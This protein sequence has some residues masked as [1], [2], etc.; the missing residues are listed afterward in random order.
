MDLGLTEEPATY[1]SQ[2]GIGRGNARMLWPGRRC[3][4]L[5]QRGNLPS[6]PRVRAG[7]G[8]R[9]KPAID[10]RQD[11][12]ERIVAAAPALRKL[13]VMVNGAG[14]PSGATS[15]RSEQA[16]ARF[17]TRDG[18]LRAMQT[19]APEMPSAL[20]TDLTVES[21]AGKVH[22]SEAESRSRRPRSY[23]V[24]LSP[25]LCVDR[26][27]RHAVARDGRSELWMEPAGWRPPRSGRAAAARKR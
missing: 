8:Q 23:P 14:K 24:A 5:Q 12:G 16:G 4:S 6:G 27:E 1:R 18:A 2:P 11:S 26:R 13:D 15:T 17:E 9:P 20:G 22:R 3:S 19:A 10:S 21:T 7:G 25:T